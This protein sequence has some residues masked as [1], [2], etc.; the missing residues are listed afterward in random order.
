MLGRNVDD[1]IGS[2]GDPPLLWW[3]R[4]SVFRRSRLVVV[5][6]SIGD[7][8]ASDLGDSEDAF[9]RFFALDIFFDC[10]GN[11]AS[12]H[13]IPRAVVKKFDIA[14]DVWGVGGRGLPY[15]V[16]GRLSGSGS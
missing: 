15:A 3:A 13:G 10:V 2:G 5:M 1:E 9:S 4:T 8:L 16:N 7:S 6:V 11:R 14:T 12:W